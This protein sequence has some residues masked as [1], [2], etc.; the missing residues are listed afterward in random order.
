MNALEPV[1]MAAIFFVALILWGARRP[2]AKAI[3][4]RRAL[5]ATMAAYRD[6]D[7]ETGLLKAEALKDGENR[8]PQYCFFRGSMLHRLGRFSDAEAALREGIP[9]EEDYRQKALAYNVLATVLMDEV[10][11]PEA[12]AFFENAGRAWPERGAN[13]RGIAEVWLRQGK[14]LS[15]ALSHARQAVDIDRN[16]AGLK[17]EALDSRLGEDLAVLS[18]ALAENPGSRTEVESHISEALRLCDQT[19]KPTLAEVHYHVARAY[20]ALSAKP[21][22]QQHI[23]RAVELDP[24]GLWGRMA[25]EYGGHL[26]IH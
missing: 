15:E 11:Y 5:N 19:S 10:R 16:A 17:Q 22:A 4:L 13:H 2:I 24:V 14:E 18:W 23:Q 6:A 7:Y 8:T 26:G 12:I 20:G 3:R 21:E 25:R 1:A 9:L